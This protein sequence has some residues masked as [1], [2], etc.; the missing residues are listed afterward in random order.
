MFDEYFSHP[1]YAI[2]LVP[3]AAA[4]RTVDLADSSV[5][6]SIYQDEPS[7]SI[8]STQEQEESLIISQ[9][10]E[11]SPTTPHF[12]DDPLYEDS[13]LK[14][15][16]Q[17]CSHPTLHLNFLGKP[18]NPTHYRG[19]IGSLMYL[20]ASRPDLVF[21]V[22]MCHWYS[23]DFR[24]TLTAYADADH[25][26]CQDSRQSTSRS[27]QFLGDKLVS[28]SSKKKKCIAISSTEAEYIALSGCCTQILWMRSQLTEYGLKFN[29]IPLYRDNKCAISLRCKN[30]QQSISKHI[31]VGYHFIKEPVENGVVELYFVKTE[32][33]L[34]D[35]ITKALPRE[36]FNFLIKKL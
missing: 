31:D 14:D 2:S 22:C 25:T 23:K 6:T 30:I 32:Y 17:M 8:P 26:G 36:R 34:A 21:A 16:H 19:M 3:V 12:N 35:I 15:P 27:A 20:I 18:V 11:E 10:V 33:Q 7:T 4:P 24:N 13:F 5:S 9:G 29:K 1:P 28:R